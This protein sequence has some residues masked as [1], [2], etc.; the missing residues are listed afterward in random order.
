MTSAGTVVRMTQKPNAA[1]VLAGIA[2]TCTTLNILNNSAPKILNG[3]HK[4]KKL[5]KDSQG[6]RF[7][8]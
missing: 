5:E 3:N 7:S 4:S 8:C 2:M 6:I 1:V